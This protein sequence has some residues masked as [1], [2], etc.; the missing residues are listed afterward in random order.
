MTHL[1]GNSHN[2]RNLDEEEED[3]TKDADH[4]N[5]PMSKSKKKRLAQQ[6]RAAAAKATEAKTEAA[7]AKATL[8][9]TSPE[10]TIPI[11]KLYPSGKYPE[12][13]VMPHPT[14][15]DGEKRIRSEELRAL[16][17]L[18]C[19]RLNDLRRAAEVHRQARKWMQ[20][21]VRPGMLMIDITNKLEAK[22]H[23]LIEKNGLVAGSAFPTGCSINHIAAH[24]TPNSGDTTVLGMDDVVKFDFGT[25]INGR[26]ID[27]AWTQTFNPVYD[28]LL[29]AVKA[30]TEEGIKQA[31]IDVR[32]CDIGAAIQEV[33]ESHEVEIK[34]NVYPVKSIRNL[35]GHSIDQYIIHAGKSVPI[36]KGTDQTKMEEGEQ[37]AIETFGSTGRGLILEDLECSHYMMSPN[38]RSVP[39]RSDKARKLLTFIDKTYSTLAFCRK[40]L[41]RDGETRHILNLNALCDAGAITKYPPLVDVKGCYTAQ[42]E[43]TIVLRPTCKEILSRGD[44]Y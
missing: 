20:S 23:E 16:E 31:G 32:L 9:Q 33:M 36:V 21:W 25:H 34:G 24:W 17:R 27:C 11:T 8:V 30:A 41:D 6:R 37:Y 38:A 42:F 19:D 22:V 40:W 12:G 2:L 26:I 28:P 3:D 13:Q 35:N 7:P 5:A 29:A 18:D 39:I 15:S 1:S 43:H 14:I 10:P 44:D 4:P